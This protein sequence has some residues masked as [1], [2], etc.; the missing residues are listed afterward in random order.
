MMNLMIEIRKRARW[1]IPQILGLCLVAYF[2][3]HLVQGDRGIRTYLKLTEELTAAQAT[4]AEVS[5]T[6]ERER[7]RVGGLSAASLD[8]D[9]LEERAHIVLNHVRPDEYVIFLNP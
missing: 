7:A 6:L 9:L 8:P 3:Y 5:A 2:A 1:V 4:A